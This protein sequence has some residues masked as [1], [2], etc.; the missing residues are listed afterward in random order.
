MKL[1]R[2][3]QIAMAVTGYGVIGGMTYLTASING[4]YSHLWIVIP[5][6]TAVII[7]GCTIIEIVTEDF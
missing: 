6:S 5:L 2:R 1:I 3:Y 7:I 4:I